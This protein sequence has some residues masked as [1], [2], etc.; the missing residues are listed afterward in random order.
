MKSKGEL[1]S[2]L[3]ELVTKEKTVFNRNMTYTCECKTLVCY[4]MSPVQRDKHVANIYV[5]ELIL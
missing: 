1:D 4:Q 5:V 3:K 2:Y